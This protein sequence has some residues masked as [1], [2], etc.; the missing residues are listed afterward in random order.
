MFELLIL[1]KLVNDGINAELVLFSTY[2]VHQ[3]EFHVNQAKTIDIENVSH[4]AS[5][6]LFSSSC[7]APLFMASS[8]LNEAARSVGLSIDVSI[9]GVDV[10]IAGELVNNSD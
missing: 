4:T 9:T 3:K 1:C 6:S 10:T 5:F 8:I 2:V 7:V